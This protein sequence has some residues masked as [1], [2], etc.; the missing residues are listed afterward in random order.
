[1][2]YP[3]HVY[4]NGMHDMVVRA[5]RGGKRSRQ[6]D[7]GVRATAGAVRRAALIFRM[8]AVRHRIVEE[9]ISLFVY[10]EG[11]AITLTCICRSNPILPPRE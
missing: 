6:G 7:G 8:L 3:L 5:G 9:G 2:S 11:S 4:G 10:S 1:M